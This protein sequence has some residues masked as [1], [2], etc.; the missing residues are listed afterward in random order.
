MK[1]PTRER[2]LEENMFYRD[3]VC[4]GNVCESVVPRDVQLVTVHRH[5]L[6]P[7]AM[8]CDQFIDAVKFSRRVDV[9]VSMNID[10]VFAE[11]IAVRSFALGLN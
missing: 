9:S 7:T 5:T 1:E 2:T 10:C 4:L 8:R 11:N 6:D 3:A